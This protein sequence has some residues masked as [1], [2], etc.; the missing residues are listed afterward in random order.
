MDRKGAEDPKMGG[1][2]FHPQRCDRTGISGGKQTIEPTFGL[3]PM[4]GMILKSPVL[5]LS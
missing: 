5:I 3:Q 1:G 4:V 2:T